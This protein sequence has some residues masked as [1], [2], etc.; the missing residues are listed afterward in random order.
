[1]SGRRTCRRL[2]GFVVAVVAVAIVTGFVLLPA[3]SAA[4]GDF[5]FYGRG[6]GHAMGFSQ[7][8]AWQGAREGHTYAEIVAFYYPG[9]TLQTAGPSQEILTVRIT[10]NP[11][12]VGASSFS[13]VYLTPT[14]C[15]ATLNETAAGGAVTTV[16]VP[17]GTLVT[18][19]SADTAVYVQ[20]GEEAEQGPYTKVELLPGSSA[21]VTGRVDMQLLGTGGS[22]SGYREYWGTMRVRPASATTLL[23]ENLVHIDD[24]AAGVAEVIPDWTM[25]SRPTWYAP[26]AV[27]AEAVAA[28]SYALAKD[29]S[30]TLWDNTNDICYKGYDFEAQYPGLR[31]ASEATAG[32]ILTYGGDPIW[33]YSSAHSGGYTT[34]KAWSESGAPAYIV[35]QADPWSLAAPPDGTYAPYGAG[36]KWS[37]T[38][39]ATT[40]ASK[41]NGKLKDVNGAYVNVGT[42]LRLTILTHETADPNSRPQT[43]QIIGSTGTATAKWSSFWAAL[44]YSSIRRYVYSIDNP[45]GDITPCRTIRGTDRYDTAIL[46]SQAMY[47]TALPSGAGL[48]VAP[49]ET[50]QEA[51]CGGPLAAAYG[52]PVLLTYQAALANNVK[53]EI[54]R[55]AP[56]FVYCIGMA[57]AVVDAVAAAVPD[58]VVASITGTDV[59]DMSYQVAEALDFA[60]GGLSDATAIITRGDNFPDAISVSPLACRQGWPILLHEGIGGTLDV[61]SAAALADFGITRAIKVGTYATLPAGVQSL[62]N[63]SGADR[64]YTCSNVAAWAQTNAGLSYSHL[65]IATG[66][67]F[68]DAL[69]AGPYLALDNGTLLLSPLNGPLPAASAASIS[70]NSGSIGQVTFIAMIEPVIS[71]VK[72]LLP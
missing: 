20:V 62:A 11:T 9:T 42:P 71:Q 54:R 17:V 38:M 16:T 23:L 15:D 57:Q 22:L 66:N 60:T 1:M 59:Y 72:A 6:N 4:A 51:L 44:G 41:I 28:R 56:S 14:V 39:S 68:P 46:L 13:K 64:Y 43:V 52:G 37:N 34:A 21:D 35:A 7:W 33:A 5:T 40:M 30:G 36:W 10:W 2:L 12:S 27:Q 69:A 55:L 24:Y 19:R 3:S 50:F 63:L 26:A 18:T 67:K 49:G 29:A 70:A 8:G 32:K 53:A 45:G 48:V 65:G 25:P 47:P 58:A 31:D 61:H